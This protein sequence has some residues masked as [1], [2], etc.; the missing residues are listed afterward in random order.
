[1]SNHLD[2]SREL[3]RL[4]AELD[5]S[6]CALNTLSRLLSHS[7]DWE[8]K[9]SIEHAEFTYGLSGLLSAL[10]KEVDTNSCR[11]SELNDRMPGGGA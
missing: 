1:M 11:I 10:A 3:T 4:T 8:R 5:T 7:V 2:H 6:A 9:N